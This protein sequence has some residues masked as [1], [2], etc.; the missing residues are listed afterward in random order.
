MSLSRAPLPPLVVVGDGVA[1]RERNSVMI[2]E[3]AIGFSGEPLHS[4]P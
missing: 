4:P 2:D 3:H 1:R